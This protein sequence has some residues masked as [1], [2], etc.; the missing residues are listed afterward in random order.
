MPAGKIFSSS[1]LQ[2]VNDAVALAEELVSNYFKISSG[3]WLRM[4]YDVKTAK[5][6]NS[7]ERVDGPFAQVVGYDGKKK[8]TQLGSSRFTYYTVCLQDGAILDAV[9]EN[10][11]L[12]LFPFIVY[13]VVHE[14]VHIV[15]FGRFQQIYSKSS[16]AEHA[17]NEEI[18]VHDITWKILSEESLP[19]MDKVLEYY[20]KWIEKK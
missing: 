19:G 15:R 6:L 2:K 5:Q 16:I 9:R 14:L 8:D 1:E 7:S 17:M 11:E 12:M 10:D 4:K 3:Q 13:I 20:K 18:K